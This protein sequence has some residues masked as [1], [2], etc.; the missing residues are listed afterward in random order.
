M[1]KI[2]FSYLLKEILPTFFTSLF[3][4]T[5]ILLLGKMAPMAE[6]MLT[7]GLSFGSILQI[8]VFVLPHLL[9]FAL[10]MATLMGTLL[11]YTRMAKDREILAIK[12]S[13]ISFY[14]LLPPA[15]LVSV[16]AYLLTLFTAI[17]AQP[18]GNYAL[19]SLLFR[20][21]QIRAD[22]GVREGEFSNAFKDIVIYVRNISREDGRLDGVYISDVRKPEAGNA[23]VAKNGWIVPRPERLALVL[24]LRDGS[25]HRVGRDWRSA[26]TIRFEK[27]A[28]TLG[29]Q[30][31]GYSEVGKG[32][33]EMSLGEIRDRLKEA[34][35]SSPEYYS[36]LMELHR[37][38]AL[39][40]AC[41]ILGLVGA[42]L[43]AQS[44]FAGT[45]FGISIGLTVFLLYYL[46]LAL[47]KGLGETG[48]VYPAIGMWV[49]NIIFA[50]VAAY[51][52]VKT[53]GER[54]I[55]FMELLQRLSERLERSKDTAVISR[56][57][58]G[59]K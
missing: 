22:L 39:P 44:R 31:T 38:M 14:Q 40:V 2:L 5:S 21:M 51:L 15:I 49:P 55:W 52:T 50:L 48:V 42:A 25:I 34:P 11:T 16:V 54:P 59:D 57:D 18:W 20:I 41:I 9:L 7:R 3:V 24:Y 19:K 58:R 6:L 33:S 46:M 43:G 32:K 28:L 37:K 27:Y 13:G 30:S 47:A 23:I 12:A 4:L 29:P 36:L 35:L 17:Y 26:Q 1:N 53:N 45:S 10:P 8:V 56:K